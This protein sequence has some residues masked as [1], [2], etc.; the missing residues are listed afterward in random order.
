MVAFE[1][2]RVS[3]EKMLYRDVELSDLD[4]VTITPNVNS[5]SNR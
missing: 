4:N 5:V 2:N 3:V 1:P